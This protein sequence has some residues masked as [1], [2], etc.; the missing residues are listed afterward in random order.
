MTTTSDLDDVQTPHPYDSEQRRGWHYTKVIPSDYQGKKMFAVGQV[1][2]TD[3]ND[4][5]YRYTN[6]ENTLQAIRMGFADAAPW[7]ALL[8]LLFFGFSLWY[9][10]NH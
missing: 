6:Y 3:S 9:V 1:T 4:S 5:L 2:V 7:L 8:V 10:Q